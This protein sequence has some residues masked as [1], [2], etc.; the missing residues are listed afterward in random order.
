[1]A[2]TGPGTSSRLHLLR[3][4]EIPMENEKGVFYM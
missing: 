4:G 3:A 2:G 1:M